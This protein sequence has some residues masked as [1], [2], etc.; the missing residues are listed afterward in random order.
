M[1]SCSLND[2]AIPISLPPRLAAPV[3]GDQR[4]EHRVPLP[5]RL[6]HTLPP[7]GPR[8]SDVFAV[9]M[10]ELAALVDPERAEDSLL[11]RLKALE[12]SPRRL[13]PAAT[14]T[15]AAPPTECHRCRHPSGALAPTENGRRCRR[16]HPRRRGL[17]QVLVASPVGWKELMIPPT[18]ASRLVGAKTGGGGGGGTLVG[19]ESALAHRARQQGR[20]RCPGAP[21]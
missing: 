14:C 2:P 3:L 16:Q 21:R 6:Q 19:E 11:R 4:G 15:H 9:G 1:K 7:T 8:G 12:L 10:G 5:L 13:R 17:Q 18:R 20:G